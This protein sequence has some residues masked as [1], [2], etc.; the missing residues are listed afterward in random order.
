MVVLSLDG[1]LT[2]RPPTKWQRELLPKLST[3]MDRHRAPPISG[4]WSPGAARAVD[5][6]LLLHSPLRVDRN[7]EIKKKLNGLTDRA[8]TQR[9]GTAWTSGKMVVFSLGIMQ[10]GC[11]QPERHVKWLSSAWASCKMVVLSLSSMQDGCPQVGHLASL[12]SSTGHHAKCLSA[13]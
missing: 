1:A 4:S 8:W 12:P 7:A 13:A 10:D 5:G 11:P 3:P 9:Q 6:A 2:I